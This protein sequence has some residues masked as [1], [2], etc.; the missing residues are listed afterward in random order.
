MGMAARFVAC[1]KP[2]GSQSVDLIGLVGRA[3]LHAFASVGCVCF[4][5]CTVKCPP[6]ERMI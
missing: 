4:H 5:C 2:S 1:P 3:H 6:I